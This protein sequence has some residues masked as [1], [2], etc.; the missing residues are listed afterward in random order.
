VYVGL[1]RLPCVR[2]LCFCCSATH[3]PRSTAQ[4]LPLKPR[5]PTVSDKNGSLVIPASSLA[6]HCP[7]LRIL[8]LS[9]QFQ[10]DNASLE[11]LAACGKLSRLELPWPQPAEV[12]RL[13][14]QLPA[15]VIA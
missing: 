7:D 2:G 12:Q 9:A 1:P 3:H 10:L 6:T 8:D 11:G 13:K 14:A 5:K 15:L 4:P